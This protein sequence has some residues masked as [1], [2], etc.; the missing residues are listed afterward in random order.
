ML[1]SEPLRRLESLPLRRIPFISFYH[2]HK[3]FFQN[4]S[5]KLFFLPALLLGA[6]LMFTPACGDSDPCKDVD[7]GANGTCFEGECV[8]NVGFEGATC[9]DAW[10]AKFV[11]SYLGF[12]NVTATTTVPPDQTALGKYNL[13]K[14]A[15]ITAKTGTSANTVIS[16]SNFGGFDSFVEATISLANA[17]DISATKITINFTDPSGRKFAGT[18]TYSS[19]KLTGNYVVTYTD[20]TTDTAN[21]EYTK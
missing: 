9:S 18:G 4:M 12:D 8:C 17:S 10:S 5:K 6:F 11:G 20:N 13:T 16:I 7:C 1:L 3:N 15:V 14:P 19:G 21:F 2:Q